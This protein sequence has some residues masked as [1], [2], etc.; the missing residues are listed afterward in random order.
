[1]DR[2]YCIGCKKK[3][4]E[5]KLNLIHF[6]S[7][8]NKWVCNHCFYRYDMY[9]IVRNISKTTKNKLSAEVDKNKL[10]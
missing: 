1:M 3:I 4:N 9:Y 10:G 5:D 8:G 6:F 2:H 7:I